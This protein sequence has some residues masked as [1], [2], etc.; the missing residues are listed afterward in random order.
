MQKNTLFEAQFIV[1]IINSII[2]NPVLCAMNGLCW[3]TILPIFQF[4]SILSFA[5]CHT[6]LL[7]LNVSCLFFAQ[8]NFCCKVKNSAFMCNIYV[9]D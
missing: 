5:L 2:N 4:Q 3:K 7:R 1:F 8:L 6:I 9:C